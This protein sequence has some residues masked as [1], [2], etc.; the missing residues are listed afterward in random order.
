MH[1]WNVNNVFYAAAF[2][3]VFILDCILDLECFMYHMSYT[4]F[5]RWCH[6]NDIVPLRSRKVSTVRKYNYETAYIIFLVLFLFLAK[7]FT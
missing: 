3:G 1:F 7:L 5:I 2:I 4:S 6:D